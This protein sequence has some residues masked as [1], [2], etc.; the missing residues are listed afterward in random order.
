MPI[1][2]NEIDY[3]YGKEGP[4]PKQVIF[5]DAP[6]KYKLFGGGVGGGK[7]V[8]LCAE[9]LRLSLYY[10]GNRGFLGRHEGE[11]LRRTTLVT[12]FALIAKIEDAIHE[13]IV[14]EHRQT[15]KEIILINGSRIL[16]GGLG[17]RENQDRIKSL[18]IGWFCVDEASETNFEVNKMLKARLRW[19][20]PNGEYPKF[21]GLYASN[22]EPG[23]VK[24]TFVTPQSTGSPL[25]D[26]IFVQALLRDNPWLPEDYISDLRRDNP[27]EWV[28]RYVDGSW[29]AMEGQIWKEFDFNTHVFPNVLYPDIHIPSIKEVENKYTWGALDHGQSNPTSFHSFYINDASD[30]F[31]T[32]EYYNKALVSEHVRNINAN[33]PID[34]FDELVADPSMWKGDREKDGNPWSVADEYSDQGID[35]IKANNDVLAG[36]NRVSEYMVVD[37]SHN[38]PLIEGMVGSPRLFISARCVNLIKEISDYIWD[39]TASENVNKKEQPRKYND[40]A[41]DSLRYGV[42]TR[43]SPYTKPDKEPE[44]GS[45]DWHMQNLR[46]NSD[47]KGYIVNA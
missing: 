27:K 2:M 32:D 28:D 39:K 40:H 18:E 35:F 38:H 15:D 46:G 8:A 3:L 41:C 11:A 1:L 36:I 13:K 16:Y 34:S 5:R 42:M 7:T 43:P 24:D 33:F 10:A 23:W 47:K 44:Y 9:A 31:V 14:V 20:L 4:T 26:H 12:M 21:F 30:I 45:F 29:E 19:Q 17:G 37:T 6:Q 25:P 22:P